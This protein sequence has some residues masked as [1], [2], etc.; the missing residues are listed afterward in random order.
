MDIFREKRESASSSSVSGETKEPDYNIYS[1]TEICFYL[2]GI[3][4]E[5]SLISLCFIR[6]SSSVILSS[7]LAVD[8]EKKLLIL[9]YGINETLNQ[10][11]LK[12]GVLHCI[13]SHN[14]IRIEF[15]CNN[16]QYIRFDDRN[17]FS[18]D[19]PVSLKRLQRR[20]FYR[21]ATP[22]ANPAT[23]TIPLLKQYEETFLI[24]NLLDISRG[25][26]ALVDRPNTDISLEVGITLEQC[27]IE[28]PGFDIIETT[29]R[30]V[31]IS[32]AVLSNG[33]TCPRIGCEFVNLPE[34]SG[35]LIQRYIIWLEQQ[36]RKFDTKLHF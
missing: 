4:Q 34:K 27:Q 11:A 26:M 14:R 12:S 18:A 15:D 23:C 29:I 24:L 5:R 2:N 36:A 13:T 9:D 21:I 25:G 19:I 30:T 16:L 10:M 35:V 6:N 31:N 8:L 7:M 17:A 1:S 3:M 20:N 33:S 32:T 28:L 22:V